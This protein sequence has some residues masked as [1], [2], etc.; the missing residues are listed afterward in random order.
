MVDK[1]SDLILNSMGASPRSLR[2]LI[3]R[4]A[5]HVRLASRRSQSDVARAAGVS[6]P[7]LRR[8]EAGANVNLDVLVRVA[9]ALEADRDLRELF[10]PPD[11]QTIDEVFKRR[12]LPMRGRSR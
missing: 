3:G 6:L 2:R 11:V 1:A 5:R 9:I 12:A 8:F 7:T 10:T 4:R